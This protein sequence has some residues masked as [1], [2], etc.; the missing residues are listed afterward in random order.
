M[1]IALGVP[2]VGANVTNTVA[3]CPGY[4]GATLAQRKR[5]AGAEAPALADRSRPASSA[6]SSAGS[7]CCTPGRSSSGALVPWLILLAS[8]LL[9]IQEPVRAW[10]LRR[11]G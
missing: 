7:C 8:G 10:L 3:L 1:L 9:A 5:P 4:L 11:M 6:A 2:A